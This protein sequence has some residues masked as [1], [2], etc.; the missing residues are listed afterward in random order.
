MLSKYMPA[1]LLV[2]G[3]FHLCRLKWE[4]FNWGRLRGTPGPLMPSSC[5]P[6]TISPLVALTIEKDWLCQGER[7]P[8]CR[9]YYVYSWPNDQTWLASH[10]QPR[11]TYCHFDSFHG[12][13]YVGQLKVSRLIIVSSQVENH[14]RSPY[15]LT[16]GNGVYPWSSCAI[17]L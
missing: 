2:V 7:G 13:R 16:R 1:C 4:S 3:P 15:Y 5:I 10:C 17:L 14:I 9:T 6:V 8:S 11:P 12:Q